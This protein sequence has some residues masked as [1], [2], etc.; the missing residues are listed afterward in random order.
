M[1]HSAG[2]PEQK[3]TKYEEW[4]KEGEILF[5]PFLFRG[6]IKSVTFIFPLPYHIYSLLKFLKFVANM[7]YLPCSTFNFSSIARSLLGSN[8]FFHRTVTNS[9]WNPKFDVYSFDFWIHHLIHKLPS[10]WLWNLIYP[11]VT[12]TLPSSLLSICS[13]GKSQSVA[14]LLTA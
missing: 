1:I 8:F 4:K 9:S 2:S 3:Y 6:I 10:L 12:Y 14:P 13:A 7:S 5:L 11:T